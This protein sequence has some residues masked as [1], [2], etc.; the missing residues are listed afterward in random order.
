MSGR[1]A[2]WETISR[3]WPFFFVL[4][5]SRLFVTAANDIFC[6]CTKNMSKSGSDPPAS[7]RDPPATHAH[8]L[9]GPGRLPRRGGQRK[10]TPWYTSF[11]KAASRQLAP[12]VA[13]SRSGP[14]GGR[15]G[16]VRQG[17]SRG[18]GS[19]S[20]GEAGSD[21]SPAAA[22]CAGCARLRVSAP[23]M[24]ISVLI[25]FV[26]VADVCPYMSPAVSS[27]DVC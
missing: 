17:G 3:T 27:T 25:S 21:V 24:L 7:A 14:G 13:A 9:P 15:D 6:S 1:G 2:P 11:G 23:L 16:C 22:F 20:K 18:H 8:S 4:R 5:A 12:H 26:H 10:C 19:Y